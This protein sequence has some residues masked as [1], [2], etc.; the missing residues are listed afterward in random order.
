[1]LG[2]GE[3]IRGNCVANRLGKDE[4]EQ[5]QKEGNLF[6]RDCRDSLYM[7][8]GLK[9]NCLIFAYMIF[10]VTHN[11]F[12]MK[13][14]ITSHLSTPGFPSPPAT[15]VKSITLHPSKHQKLFHCL[16]SFICTLCHVQGQ[17]IIPAFSESLS[18]FCSLNH[19][20][21]PSLMVSHLFHAL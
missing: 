16:P 9:S 3:V 17:W 14:T 2:K 4:G 19:Q 13:V 18:L 11:T 6:G 7:T 15:S 8:S 12:A 10:Y 21:S 1:M 5:R 20:L